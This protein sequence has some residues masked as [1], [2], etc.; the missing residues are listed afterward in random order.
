MRNRTEVKIKRLAK[1]LIFIHVLIF[2][3]SWANLFLL[4]SDSYDERISSV[5]ET[6]HSEDQSFEDE[7]G[8]VIDEMLDQ[9]FLEFFLAMSFI[10]LIAV[11]V[12]GIASGITL[13]L[14]ERSGRGL[15]IASAIVAMLVIFVLVLIAN[16]ILFCFFILGLVLLLVF[17]LI[18]L[19]C[20]IFD[21]GVKD[22]FSDQKVV[23]AIEEEE[24]EEEKKFAEV[25]EK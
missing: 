6:E 21:N 16:E 4:S 1:I 17:Y 15:A 13:L 24:T 7:I 22:Y 25:V 23:F 19:L 10:F 2:L 12:G 9:M 5:V 3:I 20:L 14:L 8:D 11:T 18:I